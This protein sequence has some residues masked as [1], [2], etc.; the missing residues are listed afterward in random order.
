MVDKLQLILQHAFEAPVWKM[1]LGDDTGRLI[2]STRDADAHEVSYHALDLA[3][4]ELLWE[5]L[6]FEQSWWT[7]LHYDQAGVLVFSLQ[8]D[9]MNPENKTWFGIDANSHELCWQLDDFH[10]TGLAG[11]YL[12][13]WYRSTDEAGALRYFELKSGREISA[14]AL[15][16]PK[17]EESANNVLQYPLHYSEESEHFAL[18]SKYLTRQLQVAPRGAVDYLETTEG[19]ILSGY[20]A[21]GKKLENFL[22]VISHEG[23]TLLYDTLG[24]NLSGLASE[25]FMLYQG[26]LWYMKNKNELIGYAFG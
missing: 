12:T 14:K 18:F 17:A 5:G 2:L 8:E 13:G 26:Q 16:L 25:T 11:D 10:A 19:V 22:L 6:G 24:K 7:E 3:T 1:T 21:T 9:S 23:D 15:T 20:F 4:G